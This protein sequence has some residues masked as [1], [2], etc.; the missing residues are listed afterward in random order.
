MRAASSFQGSIFSVWC[1]IALSALLLSITFLYTPSGDNTL[2]MYM[3]ELLTKGRL[4]YIGSWDHNFPGIVFIH[5]IHVIPFGA[6]AIGFH[7]FD[8]LCQ[9]AL[10]YLSYRVIQRASNSDVAAWLGALSITLYYVGSG[11]ALYGERDC[12]TSILLIAA[13]WFAV[14][15]DQRLTLSALLIGGAILLRPTAAIYCAALA[16]WVGFTADKQQLRAALRYGLITLLPIALFLLWYSLVGGIDKFFE[17]T[18]RYNIE[19]YT[20]PGLA[21]ADLLPERRHWWVFLGIPLGLAALYR[22]NRSFC[23]LLAMLIAASFISLIPV[24]RFSYHYHPVITICLIASMVGWQQLI[25]WISR[26]VGERLAKGAMITLPILLLALVGDHFIAAKRTLRLAGVWW[27]ADHDKFTH[28]Y[29]YY[30]P[31]PDWGMMVEDSLVQFLRENCRVHERVQS[32]TTTMYVPLKAGVEP[33]SR[34]TN[35]FNLCIGS[36]GRSGVTPMQ[37]RWRT[38]YIADIERGKPKYM[39]GSQHFPDHVFNNGYMP[40]NIMEGFVELKMLLARDY[41]SVKRIGGYTIYQIKTKEGA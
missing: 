36:A 14:R 18:I 8:S 23:Y 35:I 5:A 2:Y 39:I 40:W 11:P 16:I 20:R 33:V 26:A 31:D 6:S 13:V 38:E 37:E 34:F 12:Y 3:A 25:A 24:Y 1:A 15:T 21:L 9:L 7:L 27:E 22:T 4:P 19:V 32:L 30:H 10:V 41:D 29:N 17:A 28:T